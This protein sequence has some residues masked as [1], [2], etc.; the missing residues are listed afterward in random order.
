METAVLGKLAGVALSAAI[1]AL[2]A[3][4]GL[5]KRETQD[6]LS[7]VLFYLVFPPLV[8]HR[9]VTQTTA[10]G[11]LQL[12]TLPLVGFAGM[13][14]G[15]LL[16]LAFLPLLKPERPL[17]GTF[18]HLMFTNNYLFLPLPILSA[19]APKY[20]PLLFIMTL[21]CNIAFWTIGIWILPGKPGERRFRIPPGTIALFLGIAATFAGLGKVL[22]AFAL[23]A[24]G[25][26]GSAGVP[27]IL[28]L[29]GAGLW[30]I[31]LRGHARLL[32]AFTVL[33]LGVYPLAAWGMISL[34]PLGT[35]ARIVAF[36]VATMPS[37]LTSIVTIREYGGDADFAARAVLATTLLSAITIPLWLALFLR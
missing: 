30:G 6:G 18:L 33:R 15:G 5:L 14:L 25:T 8:F 2:G 11:I 32:S 36:V 17:R 28:L 23:D 34:F 4:A 22:P 12:W 31:P 24:L 19:L 16:G 35:D 37:A 1:G 21:G 9:L 7:K 13:V 26:L 3:W 27:M 20:E 10:E 29:I